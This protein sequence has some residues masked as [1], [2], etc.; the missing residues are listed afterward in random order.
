MSTVGSI[1]AKWK[2]P[3]AEIPLPEFVLFLDSF[4]ISEVF[5]VK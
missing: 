4:G 3:F 1:Y 2:G 5:F